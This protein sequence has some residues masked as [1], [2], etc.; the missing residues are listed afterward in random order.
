MEGFCVC[1]S[2]RLHGAKNLCVRKHRAKLSLSHNLN[3]GRNFRK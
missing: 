3:L 1:V 2:T